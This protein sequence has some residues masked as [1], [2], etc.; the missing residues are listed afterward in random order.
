M[1]ETCA[2]INSEIFDGAEYITK[3]VG[4]FTELV[5]LQAKE[6]FRHCGYDVTVK[7]HVLYARK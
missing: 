3:P 6:N 1:N 7:D 4:N 2:Q 5:L